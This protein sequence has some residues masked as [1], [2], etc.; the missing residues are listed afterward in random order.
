MKTQ[1]AKQLLYY[2]DLY[3]HYDIKKQNIKN[4]L[5]H[6]YL[7]RYNTPY[8]CEGY[9]NDIKVLEEQ[10]H[11][12]P[13]YEYAK[14]MTLTLQEECPHEVID[15]DRHKCMICHKEILDTQKQNCIYYSKHQK[16]TSDHTFSYFLKERI[17]K[18]EE[19]E[20]DFVHILNQEFYNYKNVLLMG[21]MMQDNPLLYEEDSQE[22]VYQLLSSLKHLYINDNHNVSIIGTR[23]AC[24]YP[25]PNEHL[26]TYRT[27]STNEVGE[28]LEGLKNVPFDY[29]IDTLE[30]TN[31]KNYFPNSIIISY[32]NENH[33]NLEKMK[34]YKIDYAFSTS[35]YEAHDFKYY[36]KDG[37]I[38]QISQNEIYSI[39][40][41]LT[42][43]KE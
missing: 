35:S 29:V 25:Y 19:L 27:Y 16:H 32:F 33:I 3:E 1:L 10:L 43:K 41:R 11:N 42:L 23:K 22:Q 38:N 20:I 15:I 12:L 24:F 18:C 28:V 36:M 39:I 21:G 34:T 40:K 13:S 31:L 14:M 30:Q 26:K 6:A 8:Y 4:R 9:E 5:N 37:T 7:V 17:E 2:S